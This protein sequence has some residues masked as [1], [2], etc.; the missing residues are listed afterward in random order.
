MNYYN[1]VSISMSQAKQNKELKESINSDM[2]VDST[3]PFWSL[4]QNIY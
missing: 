2:H 4:L 3:K 1:R